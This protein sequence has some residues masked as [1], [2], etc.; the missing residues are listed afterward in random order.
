MANVDVLLDDYSVDTPMSRMSADTGTN[1]LHLCK[2]RGLRFENWRF[3]AE[4]RKFTYLTDRGNCVVDYILATEI[5]VYDPN[6]LSDHC[7]ISFIKF[8]WA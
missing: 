2:Q 4:S 5:R 1:L 8:S 3:G 7:L 6:I